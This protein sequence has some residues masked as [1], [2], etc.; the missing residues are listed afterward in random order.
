MAELQHNSTERLGLRKD[1][2]HLFSEEG[3]LVSRS[4]I[5]ISQ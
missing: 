1:C 2:K 4:G 5:N 3:R